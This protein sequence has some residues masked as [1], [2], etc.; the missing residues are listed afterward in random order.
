MI[1]QVIDYSVLIYN[2][3]ANLENLNLPERYPFL[4]SAFPQY[5]AKKSLTEVTQEYIK[6]QWILAF[7]R[8]PEYTPLTRFIPVLVKDSKPYWRSLYYPE[9]KGNRPPKT[10][11]FYSIKATG[12]RLAQKLNIP[13]LSEYGYE[14]DDLAAAIVKNQLFCQSLECQ[15]PEEKAFADLE[16]RLWTVDSDWHQLVSKSVT[17]YNTGPWEP[18]IRGPREAKAWAKKRLKVDLEHPQDIVPIKCIKGDKSDNL[19]PGTKPFFIDLFNPHQ[20]HRLLAK[21]QFVDQLFSLLEAPLNNPE[22]L[23]GAQ[24]VLTRYAA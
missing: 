1:L 18:L 12:E 23:L 5:F 9:Y 14:A 22:M 13:I 7:Y 20:S 19:P 8:G 24:K 21:E 11:T 10:D 17:W 3:T 2:I 15:T 4:K 16:I 6:S